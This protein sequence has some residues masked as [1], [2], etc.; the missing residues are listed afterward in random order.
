MPVNPFQLM[1][2]FNAWVNTRL[3]GT[4]AELPEPDYRAER[5][6]FFGSIHR[7][8]NHLLVV[9]RLWM[10]RMEGQDHGDLTLADVPYDD[11]ASLR[12][13][14]TAEDE[15]LIAVVEGLTP[16][17]LEESVTWRR[18]IGEGRATTR[19][20]HMLLTL[21]NHQTHHRGQI[22][23]LL[24]QSGVEYPPLDVIFYLYEVGLS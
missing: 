8:L 9:D 15:R 18:T 21:F 23:A 19:R 4:V 16:A 20:D 5:K 13:A 12:A 17:Q 11:F 6:A 14:R 2:R 24:T 22:T 3:Y 10:G 1:A 7:T